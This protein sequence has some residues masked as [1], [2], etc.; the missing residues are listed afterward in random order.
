[1]AKFVIHKRGFFYTDEAYELIKN[2]KGSIVGTYE[3]LEKAKNEKHIQD[4]ISMQN[5]KGTNAVD[6]ILY[7][8]NYDETF[9]KI[10]AY[11]RS[12]YGLTISDKSWFQ[13]PSNIS[14]EQAEK[15]LEILNIS[16]HDIVEYPDETELN[17]EEF[18]L[19]AQEISEF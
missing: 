14:T 12:E 15:F 19:L 4:V 18:S 13:L 3:D 9:F 8:D 11:Y 17:P 1:M 5:L 10:E 7:S 16:F 6:F 2:S